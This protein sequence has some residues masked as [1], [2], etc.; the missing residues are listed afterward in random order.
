LK[1]AVHDV[2][3]SLA[4]FDVRTIEQATKALLVSERMTTFLTMFFAAAAALLC[5]LGIYGTV[6]R[7]LAT[8]IREMAIRLAL[9]GKLADVVLRVSRGPILA[10]IAG[11]SGGAILLLAMAPQIR[12]LL[13]DLQLKPVVV[14]GS[15]GLLAFVAGVAI[16]IPAVRTRRLEPAAL[17]R[18]D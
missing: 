12:P 4:L 2:D 13:I 9:G 1:T 6:S 18:Q 16:A 8:R 11:L 7:E 5:A 14:I 3:P 17:L 15:A 10:V